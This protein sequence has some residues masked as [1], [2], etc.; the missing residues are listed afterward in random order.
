[1][2]KVR[3]IIKPAKPYSPKHIVRGF[4]IP[5]GKVERLVCFDCGLKWLLKKKERIVAVTYEGA[6]K[7]STCKEVL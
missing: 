4:V 3:G 6:V 7:C 2:E 5:S 1:M